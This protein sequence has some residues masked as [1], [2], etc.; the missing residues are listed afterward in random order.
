MAVPMISGD[1]FF[2]FVFV[3]QFADLH[4]ICCSF[5]LLFVLSHINIRRFQQSP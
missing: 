3:F 5:F 4:L 1:M 2:V